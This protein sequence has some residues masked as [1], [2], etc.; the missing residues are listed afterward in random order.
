MCK[1][2]IAS[3]EKTTTPHRSRLRGWSSDSSSP[4]FQMISN[5]E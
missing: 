2:N 1:M 3:C 4:L 5:T